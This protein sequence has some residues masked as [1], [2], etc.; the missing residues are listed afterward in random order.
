[1]KII[2]A[3]KKIKDLYRKADDLKA[4]IAQHCAD[5]DYETPL[6]ADQKSQINSWIQSHSDVLKEISDLQY[7]VQ[8]TNIETR[9]TIELDSKQ[10]TKSIAEWI[11]RRKKL[12]EIEIAK[13][14]SLGDKN[15]KEGYMPTSSGTPSQ[16][17]IRRYYDPSHR[18][19]RLSALSQE[20][21]LID[22]RLEIVNAVT[23]LVE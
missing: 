16:V 15:L 4:K 11:L 6:Y 21:S 18:D 14:R 23:D 20:P 13:W 7:R 22:S 1:M 19:A 5:L 9:V 17:K 12:C 2:E 10:V 3:L 8:K